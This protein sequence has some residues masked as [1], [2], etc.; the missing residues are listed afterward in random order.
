M[1][2]PKT[3]NDTKGGEGS[4]QKNGLKKNFTRVVTN[5]EQVLVANGAV[6]MQFG[7]QIAVRLRVAG[8][9]AFIVLS[10]IRNKLGLRF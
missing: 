2:P 4:I 1:G 6:F 10:G 8:Q 3:G 5:S 9:L 7:S